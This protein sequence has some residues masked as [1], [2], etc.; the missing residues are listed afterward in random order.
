MYAIR[1][2]ICLSCTQEKC[3]GRQP[4]PNKLVKSKYQALFYSW[5]FTTKLRVELRIFLW[6]YNIVSSID[7][8]QFLPI[9]LSTFDI[10]SIRSPVLTFF[11]EANFFKGPTM[12]KAAVLR[13]HTSPFFI[14]NTQFFL[15]EFCF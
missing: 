13:L 2:C 1:K 10:S 7:W 4:L 11:I 3:C 12:S 15:L 8:N 5:H 9:Q 14:E 6:K